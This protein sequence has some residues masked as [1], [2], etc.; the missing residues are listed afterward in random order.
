M[1]MSISAPKRPHRILWHFQNRCRWFVTSGLACGQAI[2][3]GGTQGLR[4]VPTGICWIMQFGYICPEEHECNQ[5]NR[6]KYPMPHK[7]LDFIF[8]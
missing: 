1:R 6:T 8:F 3:Q 4:P 7:V 2:A 5:H